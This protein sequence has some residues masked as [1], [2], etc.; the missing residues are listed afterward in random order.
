MDHIVYLY[1]NT[2]WEWDGVFRGGFF[3]WGSAAPA[4]A[5]WVVFLW[6]A[7]ADRPIIIAYLLTILLST[8]LFLV[9]ARYMGWYWF[10]I[11]A[12]IPLIT[13]DARVLNK[14]KM[15]AL[16]AALLLLN[17]SMSQRLIRQQCQTRLTHLAVIHEGP[18]LQQSIKA[19]IR[20]ESPGSVV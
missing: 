11:I 18:Q 3:N 17:L 7:K 8:A 19:Q 15:I 2:I 13:C 1:S 5:A 10:P 14:R 20:S 9:Q 6:R 12:L 16:A 4:F